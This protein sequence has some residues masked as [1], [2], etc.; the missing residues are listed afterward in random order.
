MEK[1]DEK[2][3][4]I[5]GYE[6]FYEVSNFGSVRSLPREISQR[7]RCGVEIKR[8]FKEKELK[9]TDN[10]NGYLI[11]GLRMK[12]KRKNFYIHRLVAECFCNRRI[13]ENVVNH[14]DYNTKNNHFENLEWTTQR[15]NV[16][17]SVLRMMK[18]KTSKSKSSTGEKYIYKRRNM[19]RVCVPNKAEETFS[20]F[21]EALRRKEVLL[22][23][24]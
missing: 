16:K 21:D 1:I 24:G 9:P 23:G 6:G 18:P 20:A 12:G 5:P 14:K 17:H 22:N 19:F 10:G 15:E 11:V 8:R 2:W 3:L 4:G 13:G 7:S